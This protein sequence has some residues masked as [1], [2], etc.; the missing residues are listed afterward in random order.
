MAGALRRPVPLPKSCD[1]AP[2]QNPCGCG[3]K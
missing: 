2:T 1:S 3:W